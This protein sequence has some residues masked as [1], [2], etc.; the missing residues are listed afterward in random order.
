MAIYS[1]FSHWTWW[2]SIVLYVYQRVDV[3][4]LG[5]LALELS[6]DAQVTPAPLGGTGMVLKAEV[7]GRWG[8]WILKTKKRWGIFMGFHYEIT[9]ISYDIMFF[10]FWKTGVYIY[11]IILYIILYNTHD[12]LAGVLLNRCSIWVPE[13]WSQWR[14]E[15]AKWQDKSWDLGTSTT[16]LT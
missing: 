1:G 3:Y 10:L 2:F 9:G 15:V 8:G 14:G 13:W 16:T 5:D 12:D 11:N 7:Q 4:H 6:L